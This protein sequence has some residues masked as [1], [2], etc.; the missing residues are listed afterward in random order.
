[1]MEVSK[2]MRRSQ[3]VKSRLHAVSPYPKTNNNVQ[4]PKKKMSAISNA[5]V[6]R[7][8]GPRAKGRELKRPRLSANRTP[9]VRTA[10][11]VA[12]EAGQRRHALLMVGEIAGRAPLSILAVLAHQ[13]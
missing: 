5:G 7:G 9:V 12:A 4:M 2:S 13:G 1:M 11:A 8:S 3:S 6:P 10:K